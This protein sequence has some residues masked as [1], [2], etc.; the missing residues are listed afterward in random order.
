[1][2]IAVVPN[3]G[4]KAA[5]PFV[6]SAKPRR[7]G[8]GRRTNQR[9]LIRGIFFALMLLTFG[10]LAACTAPEQVM[11]PTPTATAAATA[12]ASPTPEPPPTPTPVP[13]EVPEGGVAIHV[14]GARFA[15]DVADT[16][17]E[18]NQGLSGRESMPW[19]GG[20]WFDFGR[21]VSTSFWM[22][23]MHFPLDMVWVNRELQVVA[24]SHNVPAPEPGQTDSELPYYDA[25]DHTVQY[26]LEIHAGLADQ[27]G[28]G[29]GSVIEIA[30]E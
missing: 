15:V 28:I 26:V 14:E 6:L 29:S 22:V 20:M 3:D 25:G 7:G 18:R 27:Y 21:E 30:D 5:P 10:M 23:D 12:P 16:G 1:H 4:L 24:V 11:T 17:E 19:D 2:T 13:S 8:A 9:P